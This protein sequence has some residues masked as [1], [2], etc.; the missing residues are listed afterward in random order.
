[1]KTYTLNRVVRTIKSCKTIE[2]LRAADKYAYLAAKKFGTNKLNQL[3]LLQLFLEARLEKLNIM[4]GESKL[5]MERL[6]EL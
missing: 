6:N 3:N 5:E 1:M 2:Q 4:M